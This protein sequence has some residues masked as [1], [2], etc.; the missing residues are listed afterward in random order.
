MGEQCDG[1]GLRA[2]RHRIDARGDAARHPGHL[3]GAGAW[4]DGGVAA[5]A[6]SQS[7]TIVNVGSA[8][9]YRAIP[10]QSAYCAAKFAVRGFTDALRSELLHDGLRV[11]LTM[12]QLPALNTPQFDRCLRSFNPKR[13]RG[14]SC[15]RRPTPTGGLG[16]VADVQGHPDER[17]GAVGPGSLPRPTRLRRTTDDGTGG[18]VCAGQFVSRAAWRLERTWAFS[19]ACAE[20]RLAKPAGTLLGPAD[21]G[22]LAA[23]WLQRVDACT[24]NWAEAK[25]GSSDMKG[26]VP[27][28]PS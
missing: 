4:D 10:L 14:R 21:R 17:G 27:C 11:H 22:L 20:G 6:R 12:V 18:S 2:G 24:V 3:S 7:G 25:S 26:E 13:P 5:D 19:G 15:L 28:S 8:L 1:D 16:Q 23:R 9:A